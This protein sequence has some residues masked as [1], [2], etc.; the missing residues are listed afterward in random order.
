CWK[1]SWISRVDPLLNHIPSQNNLDVD[2]LLREMIKEE[3]MW[4]LDLFHVWLPN[5]II[6]RIVSIPPPQQSTGS[7]KVAWAGTSTGSF[8]IKSAYKTIKKSSWDLKKDF[9]N[10]PRKYKGPQRVQIFIWLAFKQRLLTQV[11]R[12]KRSIAND[13][14]YTICRVTQ[15]DIMHVI[16]DC[17]PTKEADR[18]MQL[19]TDGSVKVDLGY[20]ATGEIL[21][22]NHEGWIIGF[23]HQLGNCSILEAE[24]WAIQDPVSTPS[25][26]MLIRRIHHFLKNVED[27]VIE[28]ILRE[29]NIEANRL[30]K[31]DFNKENGLQLFTD[32]PFDLD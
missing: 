8:F 29:E 32:N 28:Y 4:N 10:L 25:R 18:W 2:C 14:Y 1:D 12:L 6:S 5:E 22:D 27:W 7:N 24:L 3:A 30:A 17:T 20:T 9:W 21:R 13:E 15:E 23:N 11:E 16:R 26:S 19:R 31:I